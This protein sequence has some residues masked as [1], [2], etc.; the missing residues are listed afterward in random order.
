MKNKDGIKVGQIWVVKG[1]SD[2]VW[3]DYSHEVSAVSF[4]S[5]KDEYNR[6]WDNDL[7]LEHYDL[8]KGEL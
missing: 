4:D 7:L 1:H 3:R 5:F 6:E 8:Y 2:R